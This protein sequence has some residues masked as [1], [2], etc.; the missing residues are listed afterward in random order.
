MVPSQYVATEISQRS[1]EVSSFLARTPKHLRYSRTQ[2]DYMLSL[3]EIRDSKA[4]LLEK[5]NTTG[6]VRILVIMMQYP[7]WPFVKTRQQIEN[8]FNQVNY[9]AENAVGSVHDYYN[10]VSY[11][12]LNLVADVVGPYTCDYNSRH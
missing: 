1:N 3:W 5:S 2:V 4:K 8:M 10:E 7:N 6:T 12:Q 9:S 11:G